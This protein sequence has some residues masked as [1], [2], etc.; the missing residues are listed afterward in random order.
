[1]DFD[2]GAGL[3]GVA[4]LFERRRQGVDQQ[5]GGSPQLSARSG[6]R[7]VR[8][9][10]SGQDARRQADPGLWHAHRSPEQPL[11]A[12]VRRR[13]H[14]P[15][16]RQSARG[17]Q[18]ADAGGRGRV[19]EQNRLWFAEYGGNGIGMFDPQTDAIKEWRLPTPWS[20]PYDVVAIKN[21]AEVWTG[22]M[23]TDQVSRLDTA[24]GQVVN[25]L[26]PR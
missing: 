20:A 13:Q 17:P 4:D 23:L 10:G 9:S 26:L 16:R 1:M 6:D 11:S 2:L 19:D 12:G 14:R 8:E 7:Q 22:S 18:L 24:T 21:G 25:Y 5:S 3:D 15:A